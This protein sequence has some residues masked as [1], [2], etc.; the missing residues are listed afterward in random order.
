MF[1]LAQDD[2]DDL[3]HVEHV[4]VFIA[5]HVGLFVVEVLGIL[6]KD[7]VDD[8]RHIEHVHRTVVVDVAR[9]QLF[10]DILEL[11]PVFGSLK[12]LHTANRHIE[13]GF[14]AVGECG[15]GDP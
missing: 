7:V 8:Q 4:D 9:N 10:L 14:L 1:S 13:R 12:S 6:V 5:I 3:G 15:A 2:V 11:L